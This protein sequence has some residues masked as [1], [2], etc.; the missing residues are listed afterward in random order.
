MRRLTIRIF[1]IIGIFILVTAELSLA[2]DYKL[3]MLPRYSTEEINNRITP[4]AEYLRKKTGLNIIPTLTSTFDQYL[5]QLSSGGIDIGF[6]NPYIYVL[7]AES[8]EVIA[9]AVKG[10]DGDRFRGI[11]IT[12]SDSSLSAI[13]DLIGKKV[14]IVG[15]TSAG[16]YLSQ[17][18]TLLENGIDVQKDCTIEEVP[19]NKQENVVFSVYTGDVDAGFIRESA[20]DKA[21]DFIP[22]GAIRVMASTAWL[23]NWALSVSRNM[24]PEDR[25]KIVKAIHRRT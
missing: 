10:G 3:S 9:M 25:E 20:I 5:K 1:T 13:D 23:P 22:S 17:K 14:A 15:Y 19:E 6:E 24:Q 2:A 7:A 11:I 16:G 4:L 18:L 21:G 8:H 12:R